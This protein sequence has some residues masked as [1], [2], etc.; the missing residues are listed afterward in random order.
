MNKSISKGMLTVALTAILGIMSVG[1]A[2][3]SNFYPVDITTMTKY[4]TANG[5]SY[6]NYTGSAL[7]GSYYVTPVGYEAADTIQF[8]TDAN[9]VLFTNT[10]MS[11]EFGTVKQTTNVKDDY[12]KDLTTG[13][14]T[15]INDFCKVQVVTLTKDWTLS[16]GLVLSAGTLILGLND[17]GAPDCDYDDIVLAL[18]KT[19][20]TPVPA[21]VWLLGSGLLGA[22]GFKRTRKTEAAK[23]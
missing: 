16:N 14:T 2:Q 7:T 5:A 3:A 12:F 17:K 1:A 13:V 21:A 23:A 19:A 22:L 9:T 20:P 15:S 4:L 6:S 8:K 11:S 18:S 10:S